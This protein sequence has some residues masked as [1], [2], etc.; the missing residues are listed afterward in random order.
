MQRII[1]ASVGGQ[2]NL[3]TLPRPKFPP[4]PPRVQQTVVLLDQQF[5]PNDIDCIARLG[6]CAV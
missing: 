4:P 3:G 2:Q 6:T 1:G 5:D